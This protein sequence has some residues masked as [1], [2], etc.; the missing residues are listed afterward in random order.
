MFWVAVLAVVAAAEP[1]A[2]ARAVRAVPAA[3]IEAALADP[4]LEGCRGQVQQEGIDSLPCRLGV[5]GTVVREPVGSAAA[6]KA[7]RGLLADVLQAAA[8]ARSYETDRPAPGLRRTRL[9][10]HK[11]SCA[12]VFDGATVLDGVLATEPFHAEARTAARLL[13]AE[14]CDC[15]RQTVGL[16]VA[17]DA[18]PAEQAEIQGVVTSQRC[19]MAS[20]EPGAQGPK[21][22][23][24]LARAS[25]S[26][27]RAA[28]AAAPAGRLVALAEGRA[29][30]FTRCTDKGL[31]ADGR[32]ADVDVLSRCACGV[33]KRWRLPVDKEAGRVEAALPL[34]RGVVL[35]VVVD[36][37]AVVDCGPA[38]AGG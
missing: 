27:Q 19:L 28:A 22:P 38:R 36:G 8:W 18:P 13:R 16:A 26:T 17:A 34:A 9:E 14:A 29:V 5:I 25:G 4:A 11:R 23:D 24:G 21:G 10:A 35:P 1:P 12:I 31:G 37:G 32:I 3:T 7:R 33:V 2:I 6:L 15:A 30:E 20:D